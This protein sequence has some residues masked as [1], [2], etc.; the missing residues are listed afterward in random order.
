MNGFQILENS[1]GAYDSLI[2][3]KTLKK[4][5]VIVTLG[6]CSV[7]EGSVNVLL[8]TRSVSHCCLIYA[9]EFLF[10]FHICHCDVMLEIFF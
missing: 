3:F 4:T 1:R 8:M 10:H 7:N 6:E 2:T 9:V 5:F